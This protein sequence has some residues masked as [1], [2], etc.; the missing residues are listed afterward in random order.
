MQEATKNLLIQINCRV[1]IEGKILQDN[2][3]VF[4]NFRI[5][6]E[7]NNKKLSEPRLY[8]YNVIKA[9]ALLQELDDIM[10]TVQMSIVRRD[11]L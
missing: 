8:S 10:T 11:V 4:E 1:Q 5:I 9:Q 7:S 3:T 6:S 2:L